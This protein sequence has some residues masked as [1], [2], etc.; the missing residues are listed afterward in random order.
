M[1]TEVI[2]FFYTKRHKIFQK[3]EQSP[4]QL[5]GLSISLEQNNSGREKEVVNFTI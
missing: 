2:C 3:K 1:L 5:V 4:K